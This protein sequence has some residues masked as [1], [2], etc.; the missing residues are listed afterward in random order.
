MV[1]DTQS[2]PTTPLH[3]AAARGYLIL[4][5]TAARRET[6]SYRQFAYRLG[7]A[8]QSVNATLRLIHRFCADRGL[9][10]ITALVLTQTGEP[11]EDHPATGTTQLDRDRVY[12]AN[13]IDHEPPRAKDLWD[14]V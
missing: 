2:A 14:T 9:P 4:I 10:S 1:E 5:M 8:P 3:V 12:E 13:W 6:I 7:I 11:G